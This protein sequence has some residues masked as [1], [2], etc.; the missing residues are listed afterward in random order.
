[1][2]MEQARREAREDA[3]K[4]GKAVVIVISVNEQTGQPEFNF[5]PEH[6]K[7]LLFP[8]ATVYERVYPTTRYCAMCDQQTRPDHTDEVCSRCGASYR[9]EALRIAIGQPFDLYMFAA[10]GN[11]IDGWAEHRIKTPGGSRVTGRSATLAT[12]P[13]NPAGY[14]LA[15][16]WS[17]E[18][19]I[20]HNSTP[21]LPCASES[22]A[23]ERVQA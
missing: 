11:H 7:H 15:S 20:S 16:C 2:L 19:N 12:W 18:Q 8:L 21:S 4:H 9:A 1:M 23:C 22:A 14:R 10:F 17:L 13:N 5:C 3:R 6:A